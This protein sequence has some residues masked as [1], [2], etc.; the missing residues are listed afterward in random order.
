V[1]SQAS[2]SSGR[3]A[4]IPQPLAMTGGAGEKLPPVAARFTRERRRR[5]YSATS[6]QP[7]TRTE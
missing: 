7:I 4:K 6:V 2:G 1:A 5:L 3:P